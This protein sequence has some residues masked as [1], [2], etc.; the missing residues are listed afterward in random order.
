MSHS[1]LQSVKRFTQ[2]KANV[3]GL[4]LPPLPT[5]RD[6]L[7][8]YRLQ[9][10][11]QLSQNFLL[12]SRITDKI[13]K[14]AGNIQGGDV[15]EVGPGPGSITR[16]I[17]KRD[18]GRVLV[19]EKDHRFLPFLEILREATQ[20]RL[21][22]IL[23]DVLALEMSKMFREELRMQWEDRCPNIHLIG[24]LPFSVS[25][26]LIIR[27]LKDISLKRNAWSYGR[28]RMT[29]TFQ[30]EVAERLVA[31]INTKQRNRLSVMCQNWCDAKHVSTIPG[32]AFVP[33]PDVD[34]G[35]VTLRPKIEPVIEE[36]FDLVDKV[37]RQMTIFRQKRCIRCAG[38]LFP[39][40]QRDD[41]SNRL[42]HLAE[43]NPDTRP[44][45]L[46]LDEF[47]R[48][49]LAFKHLCQEN[50]KLHKFHYGLTKDDEHWQKEEDDETSGDGVT[51]NEAPRNL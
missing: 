26:P 39:A 40:Y 23:G 28:V 4:R 14:A 6:L 47:R 19:I 33:P 16:S 27:W 9:A 49:V 20:E 48:L 34:V 5:P 38:T 44:Y 50:P 2:I 18:P 41:L 1:A 35:V 3:P 46:T 51:L 32:S 13:A 30:K 12:D 24:N 10:R 45:Q 15:C 37:T 36:D 42:L 21:H 43:V 31:D 25:T 17:L 8:L 7:N 11:K 22:I 29:L